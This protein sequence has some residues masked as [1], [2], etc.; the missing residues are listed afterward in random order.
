MSTG[1]RHR[2]AAGEDRTHLVGRIRDRGIEHG[3]ARRVPQLEE[4]RERRDELLGA[5]AR[6]DLLGVDRRHRTGGRTSRPRRRATRRCPPTRDTPS[7]RRGRARPP[8]E[9][10]LGNR[11]ARRA[12]RAVDDAAGQAVG[13]SLQR[14]E[15][16]V[17]VRRRHESRITHVVE[18]I[19]GR[20]PTGGPGPARRRRVALELREPAGRR[21]GQAGLHARAGVGVHLHQH[22]ARAVQRREHVAAVVRHDVLDDAREHAQAI[23]DRAEQILDAVATLRR[24]RDRSRVRRRR[25]ASLRR[26][27]RG[28]SWSTRGASGRWPAP[29]SR[30]TASTASMRSSGSGADASTRCTS[31]S[32][33]E[34]SSSVVRNAST[35]WCGSLR[36]NPTVSEHQH[37]LTTGQ[38]QPAR[39]R[40]ERREQLVLDEDAG[41]GEPVQQRGLA[42][43]GVA[44]ERDAQ[45]L[46]PAPGL[47]LRLAR[48][49]DRCA[50][51]LRA[52]APAARA[53]AGRLRAGSRP[54]RGGCRCRRPAGS[55]AGRGRAGAA[56]GSAVARAR[57]GSCPPGSSR[58]G[59]RCRGS[60][61]A[62]STTSTL[63]SFSRLRCC[64]GVSSSSNT[65]TSMS[66]ATPSCRSSSALPLPMYVAGSG[67]VRRWSTR[68]TGSAPAVSVSSTSS[69]SDA[70]ASSMLVVPYPVPTSSARCC[71]RS[72]STSV[73]V[74]RRRCRF[75]CE[76]DGLTNITRSASTGTSTSK[77]WTTG[78]PRCTVSSSVTVER[79]A[80]HV[81]R[82]PACRPSPRRC[83]TAATAHAPVPH[84]SVSPA[85][86]SQ[87]RMAI[88]SACVTRTNSTFVRRG[89]RAS[90]SR[91]GPCVVTG[92]RGRVVDEQH[93]VRVPHAGRV[94]PVEHAVGHGF[95]LERVVDRDRDARGVEGDRPHVDVGGHDRVPPRVRA[96]RAAGP[97][98]VSTSSSSPR[99]KPPR[100]PPTR[101]SGCRC[102]SS[103]PRRRRRSQ[104]SSCSRRRR[105][106]ARS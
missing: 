97:P 53:A 96:A 68:S 37:G 81:D 2:A 45:Q 23:A 85:P 12:D 13:E 82:A 105:F 4:V 30:N 7:T 80:E 54:A 49:D 8:R 22:L 72:R 48:R 20:E 9:R 10:D 47:A 11:V 40:V 77:T 34:T 95:Q 102:R 29:I 65:T 106:R 83:A 88:R 104:A 39:R 50:D 73:A 63:N 6:A 61:A 99:A 71:R 74:R 59:R 52:S 64:A 18:P 21:V 67:V 16:L 79:A 26:D 93:E 56:T 60:S 1:D 27:R 70:S 92:D 86:R 66:S 75:W 42:R 31:R 5:D 14:V 103:R 33:S 62:R 69:S 25:A 100:R 28:R 58:A 35:S 98:A 38:V 43:V 94:T 78:P 3:V 55:T 15:P 24:D 41:V 57:P 19:G 17:R 84:E 44:D 87:T 46:A 32:A 51:R 91:T 76:R 90:C 101:G 36:T 89:K